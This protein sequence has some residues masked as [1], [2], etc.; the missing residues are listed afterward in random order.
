MIAYNRATTDLRGLEPSYVD[1]TDFSIPVV[2]RAFFQNLY[3]QTTMSTNVDLTGH[4][5]TFGVQHTF[6]TGLDFYRLNSYLLG[7][8]SPVFSPVSLLPYP[9]HPGPPALGPLLPGGEQAGGG[10][11]TAGLYVQDQIKLPY[12]LNFLAGARY[13]YIR[14]EPVGSASPNF[15]TNLSAP[16]SSVQQAETL[17]KVTPRFGLLWRPEKWLSGYIHYAEGFGV[18]TGTIWPNYPLPPTSARDVEAGLKFEAFDGKLRG[19]VA[20]YD[21]TKTNVPETDPNPAHLCP[22]SFQ[23]MS[24]NTV[25]GEVRSKG[26]EVDVGG[27]ILPGWNA[28]FAFTDM[29]VRITKSYPGDTSNTLGAFQPLTPRTIVNLSTNY[30]FQQGA[31]KGFKIGSTVRYNGSEAPVDGTGLSISRIL[32]RISGYTTVDLYGSYEFQ[33]N[34][35]KWN[36]GVNITNLFD[37]TYYVSEIYGPVI[38]YQNAGLLRYGAPFAVLGHLSAEY[39]GL[40]SVPTASPPPALPATFT[41]A[42]PYV[43]GQIGYAWGDNAGA[44]SYATPD[45]QFGS[46][47][48]VGDGQGIIFG[49]HAGYNHQIDNWVLGLEGSVDYTNLVKSDL[50]GYSD[51][52]YDG[53]VLTANVQTD[54]QAGDSRPRG[55]R[56]WSSVAF[57][58]RR[59]RCGGLQAS[60]QHRRI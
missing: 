19:G 13:Q 26:T 56:L 16:Y 10:Q 35:A 60:I 22:P 51:V 30:E 11:D 21:L 4:F 59:P 18:N 41:W 49:G 12:D 5:E 9:I 50:L 53:G 28:T 47:P 42:G 32:P 55:L 46:P 2:Q 38:G 48:L 24:C 36:A 52:N 27:E 1:T 45:G 58:Y 43:G 14:Y 34:G 3:T 17:Q 8:Y 29:D 54:I 23:S 37:K 6:L 7:T 40:P 20:V 39:P 15:A 31:W 44:F 25:A 33:Y 57:R